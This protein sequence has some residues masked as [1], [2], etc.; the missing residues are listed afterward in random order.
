MDECGRIRYRGENLRCGRCSAAVYSCC[1]LQWQSQG[2]EGHPG[3]AIII[4]QPDM[5][6]GARGLSA[7]SSRTAPL[8]ARFLFLLLLRTV[9]V[10]LLPCTSTSNLF[11]VRRTCTC[12]L[13][14]L[15]S[16]NNAGVIVIFFSQKDR[17]SRRTRSAAK[18]S[19]RV[20]QQGFPMRFRVLMELKEPFRC[21]IFC[22][23][24]AT[25]IVI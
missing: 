19:D 1:L 3:I 9:P 25:F 15:C 13:C 6:S 16:V 17:W 12:A 10:L 21:K 24:T 2:G 5:C 4:I 22:K 14:R 20:M 7:D 8:L 11:A 23:M 18:F